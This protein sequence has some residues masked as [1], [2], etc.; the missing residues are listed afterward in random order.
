MERRPIT[1]MLALIWGASQQTLADIVHDIMVKQRTLNYL[2]THAF[3][4]GAIGID[5]KVL[6]EM[7]GLDGTED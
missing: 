7:A 2:L 4:K 1:V 6:Q 3:L 5:M